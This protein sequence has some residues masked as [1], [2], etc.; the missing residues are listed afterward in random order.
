MLILSPFLVKK[1][2]NTKIMII[3]HLDLTI[4]AINTSHLRRQ[5]S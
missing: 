4:G 2:A 1:V 3:T 5:S